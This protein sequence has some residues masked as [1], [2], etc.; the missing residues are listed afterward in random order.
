MTFDEWFE[1]EFCPS[2]EYSNDDPYKYESAARRAWEAGRLSIVV[3]RMSPETE[4]KHS[5]SIILVDN[6]S[7][8]ERGDITKQELLA[9]VTSLEQISIDENQRTFFVAY[10]ELIDKVEVRLKEHG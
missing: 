4:H 2:F 10:R 9:L 1:Q 5:V 7:R 6:M 3:E 8:Y